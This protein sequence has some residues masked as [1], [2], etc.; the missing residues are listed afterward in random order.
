MCESE[1]GFTHDEQKKR[2]VMS[3]VFL[4][5]NKKESFKRLDILSIHDIRLIGALALLSTS[6]EAPVSAISLVILVLVA[7]V[8]PTLS[9]RHLLWE[10][11]LL[12]WPEQKGW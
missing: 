7:L 8:K 10:A 4:P 9:V 3:G 6:H 1:Q 5:E 11:D 12:P 2:A